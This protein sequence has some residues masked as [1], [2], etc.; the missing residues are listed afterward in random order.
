MTR[1]P[2]S[3]SDRDEGSRQ[4]R[5]SQN[6]GMPHG[7]HPE[8]R[9]RKIPRWPAPAADDCRRGIR[10]PT[11]A[12]RMI[13]SIAVLPQQSRSRDPDVEN[14]A[15]GMTEGHITNLGKI[16]ALRSARAPR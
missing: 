15:D 4:F 14:F 9:M 10:Q 11:D 2:E 8:R 7:V 13:E 16:S 1:P 6:A 5:F 12:L 3:R